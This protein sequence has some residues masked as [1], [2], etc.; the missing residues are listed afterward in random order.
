MPSSQ[1]EIESI[2]RSSRSDSVLVCDLDGTITP[3]DTLVE[4]IVG[5]IRGNPLTLFRALWWLR[6]GRAFFK[7]QIANVAIP[8]IETLPL[9]PAVVEYLSTQAKSGRRI[10]LATAAHISIATRVAGRLGF[11]SDVI[12]SDAT[13]NLKGHRKL[14]EIRA[15]YGSRFTYM[16][17]SRAD[18]AI[19]AH[20]KAAIPVALSSSLLAHVRRI[21]TIEKEFPRESMQLLDWLKAIRVHQWLKNLLV[22]VPLLTSFSF[23]EWTSALPVVGAF[24]SFSFAASST[25]V[26]N[27]ILDVESDR[28]HPRKRFRAVANGQLTMMKGLSLLSVLLLAAL[29]LAATISPAFLFV[30]LTYLCVTTAYSITLKEFVLIDVITL[31]VLY[32]I[33]IVGGSVAANVAISSWLLAFSVFVF[34]SLALVKRCSELVLLSSAGHLAARGRD[35]RVSDL[36]L[37]WP[38]GIGSSLCAIVVFGLFISDSITQARYATPALLWFVALGLIYWLSRLWLKTARGEMHDDPL[39]FAVRDRGSRIVI[40]CLIVPTVIARFVE[41]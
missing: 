30:I 8:G 29:T 22:F 38:L 41:F 12:A 27:D 33:R 15:R 5:V 10:V 37:L 9:R 7:A 21:S 40:L 4:S 18:L 19:W 20:C 3:S 24:I 34:L 36:A 35:Y 31:S 6:K 17:D 1:S 2:P 25:Y 39:V 16:G 23:G 26:V 28:A 11:V 32:T 14:E 13:R